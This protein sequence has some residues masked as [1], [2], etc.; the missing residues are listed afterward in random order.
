MDTSGKAH[1][2]WMALIPL[3]VLV[4]IV[5]V[6]LGGPEAF[7]NTLRDWTADLL[8]TAARWVKSL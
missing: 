8:G 2:G 3:T 7:V 5:M 6:A 1:E 4:A